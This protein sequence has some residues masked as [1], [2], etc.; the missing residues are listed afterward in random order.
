MDFRGSIFEVYSSFKF[1]KEKKEMATATDVQVRQRPWWLTLIGGVAAV[2]LGG[3]LLWGGYGVRLQ[4]YMFVIYFIGFYWFVSG[5]FELV[6]MFVD[7]SMWGWKLFM[8]IVGIWAGGYVITNPILS[9]VALPKI[10]VWV[11]GFYGIFYGIMLI[12]MAFKGGGWGAG[13]LGALGLVLGFVLIGNAAELGVGLAYV[14]VSALF[15]FIFGI[16]A[17]VRSF[18][19]RKLSK[20]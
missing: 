16:V 15:A 6:Y 4:T 5:I 20:V 3:L 11:L 17:I 13:L 10:A 2:I 8:G 19:Q 18:Q 9:A 14:W 1:Q 7:H 12:V